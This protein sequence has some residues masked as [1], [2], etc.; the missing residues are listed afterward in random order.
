[1]PI[2]KIMAYYLDKPQDTLLSTKST[3][4]GIE[5]TTYTRVSL[6]DG[7]YAP[8]AENQN[9]RVPTSVQLVD[10]GVVAA[11]YADPRIACSSDRPAVAN[12]P[13]VFYPN[14]AMRHPTVE[15]TLLQYAHT[16]SASSWSKDED[17]E[18]SS[19][20]EYDA[21]FR[22]LTTR[23]IF[24]TEKRTCWQ[25][26]K[27]ILK[28]T[29]MKMTLGALVFV[30]ACICMFLISFTDYRSFFW[31]WGSTGSDASLIM[32]KSIMISSRENSLEDAKDSIDKGNQES[33]LPRT[34]DRDKSAH[35][36]ETG[37]KVPLHVVT[38]E[39]EAMGKRDGA[40]A[41]KVKTQTQGD[42][43]AD[44]SESKA[45][46]DFFLHGSPPPVIARSGVEKDV[47]NDENA[48]EVKEGDFAAKQKIGSIM[49]S[50]NST[51]SGR[52]I[53]QREL[54][55][56]RPWY[57]NEDKG[58]RIF[59]DGEPGTWNVK[60]GEEMMYVSQLHHY[61]APMIDWEPLS[62]EAKAAG[63]LHVTR[64]AG[65][66][67]PV[68]AGTKKWFHGGFYERRLIDGRIEYQNKS[69]CQIL[70]EHDDMMA[71]KLWKAMCWDDINMTWGTLYKVRTDS[72][73]HIPPRH[74]W[75]QVRGDLPVPTMKIYR[76]KPSPTKHDN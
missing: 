76:I 50:G 60:C 47:M 43:G 24:M 55:E 3:Q 70:H 27:K 75:V 36:Q 69:G 32:G 38:D 65:M 46:S 2:K 67:H 63:P 11:N 10:G 39:P 13:F 12:F 56:A 4:D 35:H 61:V 18:S 37:E 58:C 34:S 73:S 7:A 64:I 33:L 44:S 6:D 31:H 57:I 45:M 53:I 25:S 22:N 49:I 40:G 17:N 8:Y 68:N 28:S 9:G 66:I 62:P 51:A 1:V 54:A 5:V 16:D 19:E 72:L 29:T 42:A 41:A 48:V 26:V 15:E 14:N 20:S 23:D 74:G 52:Y 21:A 30:L 71:E 59:W